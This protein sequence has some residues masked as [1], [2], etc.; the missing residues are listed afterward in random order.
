MLTLSIDVGILHL[1]STVVDVIPGTIPSVK[2]CALRSIGCAKDSMQRLIHKLLQTIRDNTDDLCPVDLEK[3]VIEQQN[4]CKATKNFALSAV[5]F[6]YYTELAY[7]RNQNII[8]QFVNPLNKFKKLQQIQGVPGV[9][10]LTHQIKNTK[11][12]ALK[13]LSV[14]MATALAT[15]WNCTVFLDKLS[16][17]V[18]KDDICDS[19]LQGVLS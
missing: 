7:Q 15:H 12:T 17:V 18:K 10:D 11:G 2:T 6:A 16:S 14:Q 8:V 4:G 5:L 9:S 3:V 13:R 1:A 19:F